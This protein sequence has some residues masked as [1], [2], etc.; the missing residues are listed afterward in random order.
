MDKATFAR[1]LRDALQTPQATERADAPGRFNAAAW[2]HAVAVEAAQRLDAYGGAGNIRVPKSWRTDTATGLFEEML[3]H[4]MATEY[5]RPYPG[6][7][8]RGLMPA[9]SGIP[10]GAETVVQRGYDITGRP[11]LVVSDARDIPRVSMNGIESTVRI[12]GL[13]IKWGISYDEMLSAAMAQVDLNGKG[14]TAARTVQER[15]IDLLLSTGDVQYGVIGFANQAVKAWAAA[16]AGVRLAVAGNPA[17]FTA[18]WAT[19]A[20]AAQ[21]LA[22]FA[23]LETSFTAGNVH[24]PTDCLMGSATMARLKTLTVVAG[25]TETVLDVLKKIYPN[26]S[27]RQ[28]WR[29]DTAGAA[30]GERVVLF[31]R[32]PMCAEAIVSLEPTLLPVVW[33]GFGWETVCYARCGGIQSA[34][35]TTIVYADM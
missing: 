16:G 18:T 23:T 29:L 24:Y 35:S 30:G 14:L 15:E 31:E 5:D 6:L 19:A 10:A 2:R 32:G 28:W 25:T 26:I 20:T 22:D 33:D 3:R 27:F 13:A 12:V 34:D 7:M 4:V 1:M 17:G 21:I 9:A 8:A 11:E